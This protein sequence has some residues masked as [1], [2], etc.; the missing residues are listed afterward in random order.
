MSFYKPRFTAVQR[1][2]PL[3]LDERIEL[4]EMEVDELARDVRAYKNYVNYGSQSEDEAV[5]GDT[6]DDLISMVVELTN[7]HAI[8]HAEFVR[9]LLWNTDSFS[10]TDSIF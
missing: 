8:E 6:E 3:T 4:L 2:Q 7:L 10:E 5:E 1:A 9:R